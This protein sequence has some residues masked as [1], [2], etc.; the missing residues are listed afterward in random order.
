RFLEIWN[1]VFTEYDQTIE[2]KRL[3]LPKPNIDTG[4][5]LERITAVLQGVKTVYETDLFSSFITTISGLTGRNYTANEDDARS[6][7]IIAEHTRGIPFLIADGVLPSNE[8][9]GYILRRILRRASFFGRKLGLD[10]AFLSRITDEVVKKMGGIYP[11]LGKSQMFIRELVNAEEAKFETTLD[12]GMNLVDKLVDEALRKN[13]H[14]I[15]GKDVF[16]LY[17]TYGF[18]PELTAEI[19]AKN[20]LSIDMEGFS[21]EM[22]IQKERARARHKFSADAVMAGFGKVEGNRFIGYEQLSCKTKIRQVKKQGSGEDI[23]QGIKG[24][25]IT[26]VLDETPF[27]GEMGGQVGDTGELLGSAGKVLISNSSVAGNAI[28]LSG[29]VVEGQ[30]S[31][32]D[33][34]EASIDLER[35]EDIARNHTATHLLHSALRQELG[36]HVAQRGSLVGP[37]RLRFDFSHLKEITSEEL[38]RIEH[39]VNELIR[40][41]I[42]LKISQMA[43]NDAVNSGAIALFDEKYGDNVR[44]IEI[45]DPAVSMELCG[46]THVR[47]TGE[48]GLFLILSES[49]IG[50]GLRRIEAMTGR[51]A[52][53]MVKERFYCLDQIARITRVSNTETPQK[54]LSLIDEIRSKTKVLE[55]MEKQLLGQRINDLLESKISVQGVNVIAGRIP[56]V[57]LQNLRELGDLL[58]EKLG[59]GVIV[60]ASDKDG[61]ANF[62]VMVTPDLAVSG[63]NAQDLIKEIA[64]AAGGSGGGNKETAQAGSKDIEKIDE[65]LKIVP[66]LVSATRGVK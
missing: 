63:L 48:I 30:I 22:E 35:R 61:K 8:G 51:E 17:D 9:R 52:E 47:A 2:G 34:V 43:Y 39:I 56:A 5:G 36:T 59:S 23:M 28:I 21:T 44:V 26:V 12:V 19:A 27:Y 13:N 14:Q 54:V 31:L 3:R 57:S 32:D 4:M 29:E 38:N 16:Q 18:L 24:D 50:T 55:T 41:N 58:K 40:R 10:E 6:M 53:K 49:S 42:S 7:R 37:D 62:I 64:K 46:G 15:C 20:K 45:G 25:K 33:T 11:E 66:G 60:L 65:A 1:L